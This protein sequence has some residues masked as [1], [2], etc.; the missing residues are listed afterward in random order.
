MV[1]I[2][3]TTLLGIAALTAGCATQPQTSSAPEKRVGVALSDDV[4][5]A[6]SSKVMRPFTLFT[7]STNP[8][9]VAVNAEIKE[10]SGRCKVNAPDIVLKAPDTTVVWELPNGFQFCPGLGD[11]VFLKDSGDVADDQF[12]AM[13]VGANPTHKGCH[14]RFR[15]FAFNSANMNKEYD[16]EIRFRNPGAR[17]ACV[18]DP[19]VKN[20]R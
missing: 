6:P 4:E 7:C 12:D 2:V 1:R 19:W 9:R 18:A 14:S 11:G 13:Q 20:G 8:C 5:F 3:L 16:Y 10:P 15:W 17:V